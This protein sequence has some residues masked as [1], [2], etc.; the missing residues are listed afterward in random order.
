MSFVFDG[1]HA[2]ID[3]HKLLKKAD[4]AREELAWEGDYEAAK[5]VTVYMCLLGLMISI[6]TSS[7]GRCV[8]T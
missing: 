7:K 2:G 8:N 5:R 1:S 6:V 4:D 3:L